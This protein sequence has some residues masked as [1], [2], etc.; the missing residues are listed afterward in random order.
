[1]GTGD[2]QVQPCGAQCKG[3]VSEEGVQ[4]EQRAPGEEQRD[5]G[6]GVMAGLVSLRKTLSHDSVG[7][8]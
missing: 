1:M 7:F 2:G 5:I 8:T 4:T 3:V 6:Q